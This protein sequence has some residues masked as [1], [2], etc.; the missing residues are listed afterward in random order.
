MAHKIAVIAG[1]G[2]G[3]EVIQEAR[4]ILAKVKPYLKSDL[5]FVD[6]DLGAN[7]YLRT[8]EVLP[9]KVFKELIQADAILLGAVGDPR[10][11]PGILEREILLHLRF[12]LDLYINLRPCILY[13]GVFTPLKNKT[14]KD[15]QFV[16]VRENTESV[17]TGVGGVFKK[18]TLDEIAT[19]Q[20]INTRK[21]VERCIRYAFEYCKNRNAKSS[22]TLVDK[23]NV[24]TYAHNLWRRVF[25]EVGR[26]YPTIKKNALYVDAAAM[27]FI[28]KPET[29][30]VI[31]T[32]NIFGDILTDLGAII[33]GGLGLAASANMN[34]V[35]K[36]KGQCA[37]MFEPIHGSAPDIA[38]KALANPIAAI[39]AAKMMLEF[40]DES[41]AAQT[42][43]KAVRAAIYSKKIF[44]PDTAETCLSTTAIGDLVA[45]YLG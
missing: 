22:V 31:V 21:G 9:D 27:D 6:Y 10:V 2:I 42:I 18:G 34:P 28:R 44:K 12:E 32:N 16:V 5:E 29:F 41:K 23:A 26:E 45:S 7:H 15:I 37:A 40:L 11:P 13:D 19:Q 35:K 1:D 36:G 30:D 8:K 38:G 3:P 43:E 39:L 17:Y 25:E 20:D 4:K 24:L 14:S 33:S